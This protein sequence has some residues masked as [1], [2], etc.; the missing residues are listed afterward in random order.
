LAR[1]RRRPK[2]AR[3][4]TDR[5]RDPFL[6]PVTNKL[7]ISAVWTSRTLDRPTVS[8]D[9]RALWRQSARA[10]TLPLRKHS[11]SP[12]PTVHTSAQLYPSQA[13]Y[14]LSR[15]P[16]PQPPLHRPSSS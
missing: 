14:D 15:T 10:H 7:S 1:F 4:V 13:H 3:I 12:T 6:R 9:P 5:S 2:S 11:L 16:R 8:H